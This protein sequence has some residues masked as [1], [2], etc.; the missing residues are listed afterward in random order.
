[1]YLHQRNGR[2]PRRSLATCLWSRRCRRPD[3]VAGNRRSPVA[4]PTESPPPHHTVTKMHPF[5]RNRAKEERSHQKELFAVYRLLVAGL[6]LGFAVVV[7]AFI[8]ASGDYN[9]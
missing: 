6:I 5:C 4:S 1:M 3:T 9:K 2:R 8:Y 7:P